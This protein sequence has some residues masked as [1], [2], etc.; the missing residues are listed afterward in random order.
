MFKECYIFLLH[1][2]LLHFE[3]RARDVYGVPTKTPYHRRKASQNLRGCYVY[4]RAS[5][6]LQIG[7][8]L[9]GM[10]LGTVRTARDFASRCGRGDGLET[11]RGTVHVPSDLRLGRPPDQRRRRGLY[12]HRL[13]EDGGRAEPWTWDEGQSYHLQ[14]AKY[15]ADFPPLTRYD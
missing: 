7:P 10:K 9:T 3:L 6:A 14:G 5:P 15:R 8:S 11:W 12:T 2:V 4:V 13:Q 1:G